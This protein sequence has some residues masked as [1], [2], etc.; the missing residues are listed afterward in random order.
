ME[1][2]AAD[3]DAPDGA[4]KPHPVPPDGEAAA[5]CVVC[6]QPMHPLAAVKLECGHAFHG[7][8][9]VKQLRKYNRREC[10]LCRDPGEVAAPD[11]DGEPRIVIFQLP[12]P[13]DSAAED[14]EDEEP[15]QQRR[16]LNP[17]PPEGRY[18]LHCHDNCTKYR[19]P[20]ARNVLGRD[21]AR[22]PLIEG[23]VSIGIPPGEVS[24]S[25]EQL[26]LFVDPHGCYVIETTPRNRTKLNGTYLAIGEETQLFVGDL[27]TFKLDHERTMTYQLVRWR[28]SMN[29]LFFKIFLIP[30]SLN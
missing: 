7:K 5:E 8:C 1:A 22:D 9:M 27:L 17:L 13:S 18:G 30:G 12:P 25:R 23:K 10:P 19:L 28:S 3:A 6:M 29:N 11:S 2:S 20:Y 26:T 16:R 4:S 14:D 24:P 15:P 21:S